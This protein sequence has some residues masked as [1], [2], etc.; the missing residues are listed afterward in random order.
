M[1][2]IIL[3]SLCLMCLT[4]LNVKADSA[5]ECTGG[6]VIKGVNNKSYCRSRTNVKNWYAA[7]TWCDGQGMQLATMHEICDVDSNNLWSG[8]IGNGECLNMVGVSAN[9]CWSSTTVNNK[10]LLL[11]NGTNGNIS[12]TERTAP[13]GW[14]LCKMF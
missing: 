6:D 7:F 8:N 2:K 3:L 10:P 5:Y 4:S 11:W 12:T 9:I 13:G 14:V 1:K